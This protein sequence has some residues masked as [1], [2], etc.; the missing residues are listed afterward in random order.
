MKRVWPLLA[1]IG[2]ALLVRAVLLAAD[3]VPFDGDE[4]VVALMAR[5]ILRGARPRFFYGQQYMGSL[6]AYLVAAAFALF[7]EAALVMR[8]VQIGLFAGFLATSYGVTL[9]LRRD[10]DVA[11]L[12]VLLLAL[13]PVALTLYTTVSLGGYGEALLIGNLLLWLGHRLGD[14][15]A[16]RYGRWL[17]WGLVAGLGF[18][19]LGLTMVYVVPIV[20]WWVWQNRLR[21]WR[22]YGLAGVGF[23]LGSAPWWWGRLD[24]AT[25]SLVTQLVQGTTAAH[26]PLSN[27]AIRLFTFLT[28]G[29][30][31][32]FGMRYPWSLGGPP[33]WLAFPVLIVYL[34][35]LGHALRRATSPPWRGERWVLWGIWLTLFLGFVFTPFGDDPT[36]RYFLPLYLPLAIFVADAL[37]ALS[38]HVG[39]WMWAVA[40]ALLCFNLFGVAQAASTYPPGLT[41]N[42]F[43]AAQPDHHYDAALID[44]LKTHNGT[45]GYS[46]Y[47]VAYPIAFLSGETVILAPQ[48]PYKEDLSYNAKDDRYPQYS[49]LVANSPTVV[50]VNTAHAVL[51]AA[52]REQFVALG[53]TFQETKIGA[54]HVFYNLSRKVTPQ[55]LHFTGEAQPPF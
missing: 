14:E 26:T 3:V 27:S 29:L 4:A 15:D 9:R 45:R 48:L 23:V 41:A 25:G 36:G 10:W 21:P 55:E 46:H 32:V 39:R 44:F 18:W 34:A 31:A 43:A 5:H 2:A 17:M 13:A 35:A 8:W 40:G 7:G 19:I 51:N 42:L 20:V 37:R 22:G 50:Y 24:S 6:D 53:V 47:W 28:L 11:L 52:L 16:R 30:P 49:A 1:I 38:K 12:T 54:Y 33:L